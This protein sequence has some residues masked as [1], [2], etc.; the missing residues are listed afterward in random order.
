MQIW[1][2]VPIHNVGN[3]ET[4]ETR[5]E[6]AGA[7]QRWDRVG[8]ARTVR[9]FLRCLARR[10]ARPPVASLAGISRRS[11][12]AWAGSTCRCSTRRCT[13]IRRIGAASTLRWRSLRCRSGFRTS[14]TDRATWCT[15]TPTSLIPRSTPSRSTSTRRV[16]VGRRGQ[17]LVHPRLANHDRSADHR[18]CAQHRAVPVARGAHIRVHAAGGETMGG[19]RSRRGRSRLVAVRDRRR[20][21]LAVRVGIRRHGSI[22]HAAAFVRRTLRRFRG[23]PLGGRQS[24]SADVVV[25]PQQQPPPQPSRRAVDAVVRAAGVA[26]SRW[27]ATRS[28]RTAPVCTVVATSRSPGETSYARSASPTI[29]C[30]RG[31]VRSGH[32]ACDDHRL[33][34]DVPLCGHP[35]RL[36]TAVGRGSPTIVVRCSRPRLGHRP[37]RSLS[38]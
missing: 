19:P 28:P 10:G 24:R 23:H 3:Q 1:G 35:T 22:A 9:R 18:R 14:A 26:P 5:G 7:T 30:R 31:R 21:G 4:K 32:V 6:S 25:V 33:A 16:E 38:S 13:V 37:R 2:L 34:G 12:A 27:A 29:P 36:R 11:G 8:N 20:P 15:T 17:A